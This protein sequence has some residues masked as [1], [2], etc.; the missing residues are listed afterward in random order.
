MQPPCLSVCLLVS[1]N[2][3]YLCVNF[4][5]HL[6]TTNWFLSIVPICSPSFQIIV[7]AVL[8]ASHVYAS[9]HERN[10]RTGCLPD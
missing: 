5:F 7:A 4:P 6:S 3:L 8:Q 10:S 1:N 9:R 2:K